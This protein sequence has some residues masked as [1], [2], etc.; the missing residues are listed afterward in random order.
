M[1]SVQLFLAT[2]FLLNKYVITKRKFWKDYLFVFVKIF[3]LQINSVF[4]LVMYVTYLLKKFG[5][6]NKNSLFIN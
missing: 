6:R 4:D 3:A 1:K 5:K 2:I